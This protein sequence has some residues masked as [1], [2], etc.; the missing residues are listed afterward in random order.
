MIQALLACLVLHLSGRGRITSSGHAQ[1]F[2]PSSRNCI[3]LNQLVCPQTKCAIR[4]RRWFSYLSANLPGIIISGVIS[5]SPKLVW[6]VESLYSGNVENTE[7][8]LYEG[9]GGSQ[10]FH[11]LCLSSRHIP[12]K[13]NPF[14]PLCACV[15]LCVSPLFLGRGTRCV[16]ARVPRNSIPQ[17]SPVGGQP[18]A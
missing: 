13:T 6:W 2:P 10:T 16:S 4:Q 8:P 9:M 12:S 3:K 11:L 14:L 5:M 15:C 18:S 1:G 17:C 7:A